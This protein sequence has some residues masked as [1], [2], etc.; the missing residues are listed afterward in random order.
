M[1]LLLML[2]GLIWAAAAAPVALA[3]PRPGDPDIAPELRGRTVE[4]VRILGNRQVPTAVIL[5]QI[6]TREGDPFDPATVEADY[7]RVFGLRAFSNVRP[8]VEQTATGVIVT[9]IVTEQ[10]QITS[11][12]FVG[13]RRISN[14]RLRDA[15]DIRRGDAIDDFRILM[16]QQAIEDLYRDRNFPFAHVEVPQ[17][18]RETGGELVFRIVEG[19]NVRVRKIN[20][21]GN[22][23]FTSDRLR[24]QIQ[25]RHW[26][27]IFRAGSFDPAQLEDDVGSLRRFYEQE[28]FFDVRVGR[29]VT[30]SPD[31]TETMVTFVIEEGQR[32]VIDRVSFQGNV[33]V[34]EAEL[35]ERL[36]LTEGR[37]FDGELL[38]R[39]V[40]DIV[41]VYSPFG[42]IYQ[43]QTDDPDYLRIDARPLFRREAG[44][45]ELVYQINEGRPFNIGRIIVVGNSRT[46]EKTVLREMRVAPGQLFNS[47]ELQEARER[48]AATP[49]FDGVNIT[50]IGDRPH[51][52]DLLVEVTEA[53]TASFHVGA[54][55]S[56]NG[57]VGGNITYE[58]RNFDIGNWPTTWRDVFSDRAFIGAG[59]HLRISLEPGTR[60]SNASI[61]FT[62]PWLFDQPYSFTTEL[63]L[64][65]RIRE[66][67]NERRTGGRVSLGRRFDYI[68]SALVTL[69]GENVRIS[70][71]RFPVVRAPD[72]LA[73]AGNNTLTSAEL[74]VRRDTTNPGFFPHR[75]SNIVWAWE[76]A[77]ALG[78]D[79]RFQKYTASWDYYLTLAEDL[80]D[81]RTVLG[82]HADVGYIAGGAP[83]FE[84]FYGGGIGSIRGFEFR[85]VSP[86]AGLAR[87]R[88]GGEFFTTGT[89]ELSFPLTGENFRGVVFTD[90]GTVEPDFGFGRI[91]WS[92]GAGIRLVLPIL[93]QAPLALDFA[94]P[95]NRR[96]E[97]DTQL[98]SFSFGLVQ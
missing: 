6:R 63:Y 13:N 83:F 70:S 21:I 54:G 36:R 26:I 48:I 76:S 10:E 20:F 33:S 79:F 29:H 67:Y 23:S 5:N 61:R 38:Q 43:P 77:G 66:A 9:F 17:S 95:I 96:D 40:R 91:R 73:L 14:A 56:S 58:Q 69:R 22:R 28:G 7:Q 12:S 47:A 42:F 50:P 74:Q 60:F 35:R 75:G 80:L 51:E 93:G 55:F 2:A 49:Y 57:G 32:Y 3:Q 46:Q 89:V 87:D 34:S 24:A 41:R 94:V 97:D 44:T 84:R 68:W 72:I 19:P 25:T 45:I 98:I 71:I 90:L 1:S 27:W 8:L 64:A 78:G 65:D 81:R 85:G 16:S 37:H 62:E 4:S 92:V 15:V 11:I 18:P 39:D 88:I 52:R 30:V 53:R 59:Q 86:R 31:Q 82:L